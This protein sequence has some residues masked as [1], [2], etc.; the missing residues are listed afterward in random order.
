MIGSLWQRWVQTVHRQIDVRPAAMVRILIAVSVVLDQLWVYALGLVPVIYRP[1][2]FGGMSE[3]VAPMYLMDD[4]FG[5]VMA[6]THTWSIVVIALICTALGFR[7]RVFAFIAM[8]FY[9]QLLHGY[10]MTWHGG[11]KIARI[12]LLVLVFAPEVHKVWAIDGPKNPPK[13][14][15]AWPVDMI[16]LIFMFIYIGAGFSKLFP[17]P[18]LWLSSMKPTMP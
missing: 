11:G 6:G 12:T 14:M 5:P 7:S 1:Y 2:R 16:R 4:F 18:S 9:A 15:K 10:W 3:D 8:F 13:T 17:E